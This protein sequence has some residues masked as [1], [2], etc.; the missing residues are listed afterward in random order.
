MV[1]GKWLEIGGKQYY[2]YADGKLAVSTTIDG[3]KVGE[4]GARQ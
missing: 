2:F 1:S 3:Y 4:D